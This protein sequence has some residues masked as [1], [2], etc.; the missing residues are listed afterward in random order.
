M[1]DELSSVVS[2][3]SWLSDHGGVFHPKTRFR[4]DVSGS[5]VI[6]TE[7]MLPDLTVVSCPFDLVITQA[8]AKKAVSKI[9]GDFTDI[10]TNGWTERQWISTYISLHWI[11]DRQDSSIADNLRHD[12][13]LD[14]L[15]SAEN[16][17]TPL[18]FSPAERE[19]FKGTNLY[20][21]TADRER[22]WRLEWNQC[23][24][25][26]TQSKALLTE[27]FT[28]EKY[29]TA[30]TYLSSR[31]FPS[32]LLS[33]TPS[34]LHSPST[35]PILIPGV[36]ALNHARG[37]P[38]SWLVTYPDDKKNPA[39]PC[40]ASKRPKISLVIHTPAVQGQELF[41]NYGPKPNSELILGYGFSIPN[42]PDDTIVLK[43]GGI[44]GNKWEIG[45][46]ASGAEG[47]WKEVLQTF[48][49]SEEHPATYED[50]LDAS[51]ML[52]EMVHTLLQRLPI[53]HISNMEELRPEVI[54]MFGHYLEGQ[55]DILSSLL[56][57]CRAREQ[58]A[59]RMAKDEGIDLVL[60]EE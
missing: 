31:A 4:Q 23:S 57:F 45:R 12:R 42:N 50:F 46:N 41:N 14:T 39:L 51:G 25:L 37:Q 7:N 36:D 32:S 22:E 8:V 29:L 9:L 21:A 28:W 11:I 60:E 52:E 44:G 1:P 26:V 54:T 5:G 49:Q 27:L 59:L 56:E 58:D 55:R 30:A 2:L 38:V 48:I 40:V 18:H 16:L 43:I 3:K 47:L 34:L 53:G 13:Y 17:R 15:P 10:H 33:A 24:Q 35:Q 19:I 20:G 6:A